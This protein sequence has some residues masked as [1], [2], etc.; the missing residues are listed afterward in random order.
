MDDMTKDI[1]IVIL[2]SFCTIFATIIWYIYKYS[3]EPADKK[4]NDSPQVKQ[5]EAIVSVDPPWPVNFIS[6]SIGIIGV[7]ITGYYAFFVSGA[8]EDS[9]FLN[10][11]LLSQA[12]RGAVFGLCLVGLGGIIAVLKK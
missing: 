7:L 6:L 2:I 10:L 3:K 9:E 8:P 1:E 4:Q 5:S 12:E 11:G